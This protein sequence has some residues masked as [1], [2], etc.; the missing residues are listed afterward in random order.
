MRRKV[1]IALGVF[2]ALGLFFITQIG[3]EP[4]DVK[5]VRVIQENRE[6]LLSLFGV[7]GAGIARDQSNRIIGVMVYLDDNLTDEEDLPSRL[8]EFKVYFR[9]LKE[10]SSIERERMIIR[11]GYYH[12]LN[13]TVDK[14]VYRRNETLMIIIRNHSN[15][16]FSFGNS[17]YGAYF[18]R[19]DGETWRF[20]AGI[21]SLQVITNLDPGQTVGIPYDLG[22]K[23]FSPGRYRVVSKGWTRQEGE[24]SV[25]GYAEFTV[26]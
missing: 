10:A 15:R 22:E 18:E 8:G 1:L 19:W 26:I 12:L 6:K 5:V 17:V 21:I 14:E 2:V 20:Y 4:L 11:N 23:P 24:T 3:I 25:W 13:V 16:T 7:V 9:R